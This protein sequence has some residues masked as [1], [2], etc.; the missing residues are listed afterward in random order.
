[1]QTNKQTN[2]QANVLPKNWSKALRVCS[3]ESVCVCV[4]VCVRRARVAAGNSFVMSRQGHGGAQQQQQQAPLSLGRWDCCSPLP[5][6]QPRPKQQQQQQQPS[7][8]RRRAHQLEEQQPSFWKSTLSE[9]CCLEFDGA[10]PTLHVALL[11]FHTHQQTNSDGIGLELSWMQTLL[12]AACAH[13]L[14]QQR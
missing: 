4:C 11:L 13:A 12:V 3:G 7:T 9:I 8:Q 5:L 10:W 14:W 1:M 6:A 2:K